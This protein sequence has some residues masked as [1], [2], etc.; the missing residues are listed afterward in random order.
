MIFARS[1][2]FNIFFF[3]STSL[4]LVASLAV[5]LFAPARALA[6]GIFWARMQLAA[7]RLICGIHLMVTGREHLPSG[8]ALIAS[9]H[10]SAFDT[11]VWLTLVP[12]A[13]Y[14]LKKEL[15]RI[16]LFGGLLEPAGMIPVDREGGS[17][18]MRALMRAGAAAARAGK[19]IVIFPEGTRAEPGTELK[20]HPGVAALATATGLPVI[21]VVTDSGNCWGRRSFHKRPGTIRLVVLPPLPTGLKRAVLMP[22]L[23]AALHDGMAALAPGRLADE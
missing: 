22:R 21:P 4:L 20:I 1:L 18:A 17:M 14:V 6:V 23:E 19:Q 9:R 10:E 12:N 11:M 15:L 5:R 8:A 2:L 7:A 3:A 13:S 16:P